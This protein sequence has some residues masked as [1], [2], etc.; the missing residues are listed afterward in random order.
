MCLV[1][2]AGRPAAATCSPGLPA[3]R[4]V[5]PGRASPSDVTML[6]N[7]ACSATAVPYGAASGGS[8]RVGAPPCPCV[9]ARLRARVEPERRCGLGAGGGRRGARRAR[10]R[11]TVRRPGCPSLLGAGRTAASSAGRGASV[12]GARGG[13]GRRVSS[14][15]RSGSSGLMVRQGR[16]R[17]RS[18][19]PARC[20]GSCLSIGL[21]AGLRP[22]FPLWTRLSLSAGGN[23]LII[24]PYA[25]RRGGESG[26]PRDE[27]AANEAW[28][29]TV[30][31]RPVLT[32]GGRMSR[33]GAAGP[34]PLF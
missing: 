20:E 5:R 26:V 7:S 4:A 30:R 25:R 29:C 33:A 14:A 28:D 8:G 2:A 31:R 13:S 6:V 23:H 18:A 10:S 19:G 34:R 12:W 22:L 15:D 24:G 17:C 3:Y 32:Y 9:D 11:P 21:V 16:P 27:G 1:L